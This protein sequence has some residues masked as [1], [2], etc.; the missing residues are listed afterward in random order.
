MSKGIARATK[1]DAPGSKLGL[2]ATSGRGAHQMSWGAFV[3]LG[4]ASYSARMAIAGSIR[5][6]RNAGIQHAASP[7]AAIITVT[8]MN[9]L[10]Q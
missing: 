9:V 1:R 2:S 4:P 5:A 3:R 10:A 6:A 8:P 7:I